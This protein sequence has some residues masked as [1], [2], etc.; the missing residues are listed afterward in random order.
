[1]VD[2]LYGAIEHDRQIC[3]VTADQ[4]AIAFDDAPVHAAVVVAV[5]I[6]GRLPI[7]FRPT[8]IGADR[9]D[10]AVPATARIEESRSRNIGLALPD[11]TQ[12]LEKRSK[13]IV[14]VVLLRTRETDLRR[15]TRPGRRGFVDRNSLLFGN[16]PRW[17]PVG[18]M[19]PAATEVKRKTRSVDHGP[20][21]AAKPRTRLN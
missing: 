8:D 12:P 16:A 5:E 14:K 18:R 3:P 15:W 19:Q 9:I 21:P 7:Q 6:L 10:E 1:M 4:G 11:V 17:M 2:R 20:C 13:G